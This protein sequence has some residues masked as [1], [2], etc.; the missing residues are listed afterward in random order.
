MACLTT[1]DLKIVKV[2]KLISTAH[3]SYHVELFKRLK[4]FPYSNKASR[5]DERI[6]SGKL[7]V[8]T[9]LIV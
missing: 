3:F 6:A 1:I 5:D 8:L 4:R 9:M 2:W 7:S